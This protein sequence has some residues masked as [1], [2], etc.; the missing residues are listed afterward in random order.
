MDL[1][2]IIKLGAQLFSQTN[3]KTAGLG[4]NQVVAALSQLLGGDPD[5]NG[6]DLAGLVAGLNGAGLAEIAMSWLGDG[7]NQP[8]DSEQL[9]QLFS[10]DQLSGFAQQLGIEQEEAQQGLS[11]VLPTILDKASQGGSLLGSDAGPSGILGAISK[12]FG[13]S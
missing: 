4:Q 13:R 10:S 2:E 9:S 6:I 5:G 7:D 3:D 11:T 8:I 1:N 12:L